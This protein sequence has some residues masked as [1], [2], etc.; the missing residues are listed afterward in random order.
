[1]N[2]HKFSAGSP[3]AD[4]FVIYSRKYACVLAATAKRAGCCAF[5]NIMH[6][7]EGY[8]VV[9]SFRTEHAHELVPVEPLRSEQKSPGSHL[10]LIAWHIL[11]QLYVGIN[12]M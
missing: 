1:M 12:C 7:R 6:Q 8:I 3:N 11:Q 10:S 4:R 2:F 9:T 5:F